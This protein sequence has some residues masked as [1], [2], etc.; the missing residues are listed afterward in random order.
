[1]LRNKRGQQKTHRT[2]H[3]HERVRRRHQNRG[4]L[5]R[6][7]QC[8]GQIRIYG[9]RRL[10]EYGIA[11]RR[12]QTVQVGLSRH[13]LVRGRLPLRRDSSGHG[14]ICRSGQNKVHTLRQMRFNLPQKTCQ[15]HTCG[16]KSVRG[17]LQLPKGQGSARDLQERLYRLRFV[18]KELSKRGYHGAKQSCG[19][20]LF[21]MHGVRSVHAKM[22]A[23]VH[24]VGGIRIS[25]P[26][27]LQQPHCS[28]MRRYKGK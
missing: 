26:K 4:G 3:G 14:R 13:G 10:Q 6:R 18:P 24:K 8:S 21:K 7:Q 27:S 25:Q 1:M 2:N 12:S 16:R 19:Y 22:S 17:L 15:T 28:D 11:W 20:R 23:K 9:L 5:L